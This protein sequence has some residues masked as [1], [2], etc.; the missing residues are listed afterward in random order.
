MPAESPELVSKQNQMETLARAAFR[1]LTAAE[2]TLVRAACTPEV[3]YPGQDVGLARC[4]LEYRTR[5]ASGS[6]PI[7]K[8]GFAQYLL[9]YMKK[10]VPSS[11]PEFSETG[12]PGNAV[13][14]WDESRNI[15]G[16]VIRWLSVDSKAKALV[17]PTGIQLFGARITGQID[18][19][20]VNVPFRISLKRCRVGAPALFVNS[21]IPELDLEGSWTG[22]INLDGAHIKHNLNLRFGFMANGTVRLVGAVVEGMLSCGESSFIGGDSEAINADLI[23]V[24]GAILLRAGTAYKGKG[25]PTP[26]RA[27]GAVR[28]LGARVGSDVDCDGG[29]FHHPSTDP[30]EAA[31]NLER[32]EVKGALILRAYSYSNAKPVLPFQADGLV[33]LQGA[34]VASLEDDRA[35]WDRPQWSTRLKLDGFVYKGIKEIN[36]IPCKKSDRDCPGD[37]D[38]RLLW[39]QR[40]ISSATQPYRQLA[41][42]LQDA[43]DTAGAKQVLK[44]MESI[45]SAGRD[46]WATQWAKAMIGYG[47]EP[48]NAVVLTSVV[49]ALGWILYRRSLLSIVPSDD[50]AAE[51]LKSGNGLPPNYPRFS[52]LFYSLENTFPLVTL[53]QCAKWQADAAPGPAL[54]Q[55]PAG[56]R[57]L[58][59]ITSPPFIRVFMWIQILLGWLLATFF[60]AAVSG[61]VQHN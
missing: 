55:D 34:S 41:K 45:I 14:K 24:G 49:I 6:L 21:Q 40:D 28:L 22:P 50:D 48:E 47:Y 56:R 53:G 1:D 15:R 42:V 36:G 30:D 46:S 7:P 31:L 60:L 44:R 17:D 12:S 13:K 19:S 59:W 11:F 38:V 39:L 61:L 26:F 27:E 8:P 18:L 51:S 43:G 57:F 16:E 3:A 23:T 5:E 54:P 9:E 25:E 33:N 20:Y 4:S 32:A 29:Q 35:A 2:R 52:P 37:A 10:A 58:A